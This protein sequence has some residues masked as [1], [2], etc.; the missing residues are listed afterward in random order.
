[1]S[2]KMIRT[3]IRRTYQREMTTVLVPKNDILDFVKRVMEK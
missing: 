3:V 1:M 2:V